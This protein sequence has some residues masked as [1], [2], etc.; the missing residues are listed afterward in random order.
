M[1]LQNPKQDST[2]ISSHCYKL[3]SL[4]LRQL[5]EHYQPERNEPAISPELIEKAV[6]VAKS[7]ADEIARSEGQQVLLEEE[8]ELH[9]PFL[10][11]D[12]GYS[13]EKI[14]GVPPGLKEFLDP[15]IT[16]GK[17]SY[18]SGGVGG[19]YL[20]ETPTLVWCIYII[21]CGISL[22]V[23]ADLQFNQKHL[24]FGQFI[25]RLLQVGTFFLSKK[26]RHFIMI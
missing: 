4:Q 6:S 24:V 19:V 26:Y 16:P 20:Y 18:V 9:L 8:P 5:L 25:L 3:N 7:T 13:S 2:V 23:Y 11:P 14:R 10:L 12:D 22:Q 21:Y 17:T 15:L 1:L